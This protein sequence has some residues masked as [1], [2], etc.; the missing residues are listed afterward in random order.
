MESWSNGY[1]TAF[2]PF[3]IFCELILSAKVCVH[4]PSPSLRRDK[5]SRLFSFDALRLGGFA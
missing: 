4:L 1:V 3:V 2:V 5:F